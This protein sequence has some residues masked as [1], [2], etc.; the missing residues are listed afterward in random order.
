[1]LLATTFL[2]FLWSLIVIFFMVIFFMLLFQII[3]DLI[4]RHD[5]SGWN[6]ALW[7]IFLVLLPFIGIFT[8][9]I[10]NGSGMAERTIASAQRNQAQFDD[11][12]RDVSSGGSAAEI[13]KA[14]ELLD[15]GAISQAEF[16][17]L[18]AKALG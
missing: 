15:S 14:K 8:Y 17:K 10:V 5:T 16:D 3:G 11:Y 9:Y 7:V 1:M 18:K 6:K 2:T 13:A 4:R 12:V